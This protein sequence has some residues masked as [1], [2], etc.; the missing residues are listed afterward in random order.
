MRAFG[1]HQIDP[2]KRAPCPSTYFK[3]LKSYDNVVKRSQVVPK[4]MAKVLIFTLMLIGLPLLGVWRAGKDV[5]SYLEFPPVTRYVQHAP[6][7]WVFFFSVAIFVFVMVFPFLLQGVKGRRPSP[8]ERKRPQEFPW[9]GYSALM[10]GVISWILAWTRFEWL[11]PLQV[12]TFTPLW[13]CYIIVA[14]ALAWKRTG[15]CMMLKRP[16]HFL[17]LFPMSAGFWWFFEYL[18]RFVQNWYYVEVQRFSPL[19]YFLLATIPFSTVLPAVL[20]TREF[21]L[22]FPSLQSAFKSTMKMER[23]NPKMLGLFFL[24]AYGVGLAL[25]GVYPNYLYALLW[26]SPVVIIISLQALTGVRHIFSPTVEGDW[27][28]IV[29]SSLAALICG[30]FWEMWNYHSLAKWIYSVP[31]VHRFLVFEMPLLG[32]AGY[33]PFGLECAVIGDIVF[34]LRQKGSTTV[35]CG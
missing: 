24:V 15:Q 35:A 2:E 16:R 29:S 5:S 3:K 9:W 18:N 10:L 4:V 23:R 33:L 17:A 1:R 6:F 8:L 31:Y 13:L 19:E 7:S 32:Y 22:T 26:V 12:H 11:A 28:I 30:F 20:S 27:R 21:L 34:G 14:N 25:I